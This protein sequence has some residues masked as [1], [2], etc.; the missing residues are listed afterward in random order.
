MNKWGYPCNASSLS[1]PTSV[2]SQ[3]PN[4]HINPRSGQDAA[5]SPD[6]VVF[7]HASCILRTGFAS[8]GLDWA[9][10]VRPSHCVSS[11]NIWLSGGIHVFRAAHSLDTMHEFFGSLVNIH[12][13]RKFRV[14]PVCNPSSSLVESSVSSQLPK[15][16]SRRVIFFFSLPRGDGVTF[17][18]R[19]LPNLVVV[20]NA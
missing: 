5:R 18:S 19:P 2:S 14:N 20:L 3:K 13:L 4:A 6:D 15:K 10:A 12:G 11:D 16:V 9:S 17:P 1:M 8:L 7:S